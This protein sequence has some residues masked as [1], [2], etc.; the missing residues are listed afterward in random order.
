M[1]LFDR[2]VCQQ[3]WLVLK[4]YLFYCH[5]WKLRNTA[6][7]GHVVFRIHSPL[8]YE[9][10]MQ[11]NE[12]WSTR[13]RLRSTNRFPHACV[14]QGRLPLTKNFRKFRFESKWTRSFGLFHWK[15]SGTTAYLKRSLR[16]SG[17]KFVFD[18]QFLVSFT[19]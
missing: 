7:N 3:D 16:F 12:Y 13:V 15:I 8:N 19:S 17:G 11:R 1:H 18:L 9:P 10:T 14:T 6:M 5:F 4:I 2:R